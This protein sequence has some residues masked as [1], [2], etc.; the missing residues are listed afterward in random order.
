MFDSRVIYRGARACLIFAA[1][2]SVAGR[3]RTRG[4]EQGPGAPLRELWQDRRGVA[5]VEFALVVGPFLLLLVGI[6]EISMMYFTSAVI[7][8]ATKEAAR[9]IRTGQIQQSGDPVTTFQSEL[10][11]ALYNVIDCSQVIFNVQTFDSFGAVSMPIEVD[12]DG[13]VVNTG[14]APGGSGAVTVVRSIYR[15]KFTTPLIGKVIPVGP[16]G[17]M[18]V[19]TVAFQ[20]EP[21]NVSDS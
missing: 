18:L 19:S 13:E 10:C 14:F 16:G 21:Y 1:R 8:G 6:L 5:A 20:N 12:E 15:W 17:H 4:R 11:D 3:T 9:Q 7:E 2:V